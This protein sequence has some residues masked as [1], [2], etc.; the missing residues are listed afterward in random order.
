M[1]ISN[2]KGVD[3]RMLKQNKKKTSA[4]VNLNFPP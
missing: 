1:Q 2:F 4:M 3:T